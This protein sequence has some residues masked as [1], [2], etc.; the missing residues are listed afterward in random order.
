MTNID[1]VLRSISFGGDA[2]KAKTLSRHF[3][4][5]YSLN[6]LSYDTQTSSQSS[7]GSDPEYWIQQ[8][9]AHPDRYVLK[10]QLEGGGNLIANEEM[11]KLLC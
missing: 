6:K 2:A 1:H 7:T 3:M 11:K 10:P 4:P 5:Q 8:A 9:I